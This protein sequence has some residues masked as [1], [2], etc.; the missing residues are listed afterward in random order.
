MKLVYWSG[1]VLG[2]CLAL[3]AADAPAAAPKFNAPTLNNAIPATNGPIVLSNPDAAAVLKNNYDMLSYSFGL[4][5]GNNLK[6]N[7]IEVD[8]NLIMR[9]LVDALHGS[10]GLMT[11]AEIQKV[12]DVLRREIMSKR[13]A[14]SKR[15]GEK[16][17][18]E[19]EAFLAENAKKPGVK[20]MENGLQYKV[21]KEGNGPKPKATDRVKVQYRGTLL[22]GQE[23]D[24]SY[25][26][27]PEP[28]TF[29]AS[30][31]IKGWTTALTN[32]PVGSKWELYIPAALAYGE[33]GSGQMI[34]P[35]S[36][37]IF[38]VD[39]VDIAQPEAP[40]QPVT[41]DIIKVPSK[42]ELDKGAKIE[43]IKPE[44]LAKMTNKADAKP[45]A[46]AKPATP[47]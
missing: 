17:K 29:S 38:E 4:N 33:R 12:Q 19:G 3:Q 7:E 23:F 36:A 27:G 32:M 25:K 6:M 1:L 18:A 2:S 42:A 13:E 31:V 22:N 43:I 11:Q 20:T 26:R 39:L 37:L 16:N 21:I 34:E 41:S 44:D 47:K 14:K 28:A 24:S 46:G 35:N 40:P 8:T 15:L 10:T 45:G 30:G 9:G 5:M